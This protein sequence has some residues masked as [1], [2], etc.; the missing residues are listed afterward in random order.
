MTL[1]VARVTPEGA[2]LSADMRVTDP[3]ATSTGFANTGL[4]L[5]LLSPNRFAW[6]TLDEDFDATAS[7]LHAAHLG[8]GRESDFL[9]AGLDPNRLATV[10]DGRTVEE[11]HGWV[12]DF[13]A[14]EE[15]QR[16]YLRERWLPQAADMGWSP[17]QAADFEISDR[18]MRGM[19]AVVHGLRTPD[20]GHAPSDQPA[21]RTRRSVRLS[22]TS[23]GP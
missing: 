18:M 7:L 10:K 16:H 17:Q 1:A 13:D 4:K 3:D 12:G 8:S 22:S 9:V 5:V 2:R 19:Q 23:G 14:F 20:K 11:A 21:V 15:Y 6:P